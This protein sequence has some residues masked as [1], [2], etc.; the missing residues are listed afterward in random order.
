MGNVVTL[1]F[2]GD[3]TKLQQASKDSVKATDDVVDAA[4]SAGQTFQDS[5]KESA[6]F[7]DKIGKLGAGITGMGDAVDDASGALQGLADIQNANVERAAALARAQGDVE[8]AQLDGKQAARDLRQAQLDVNQ[9]QR[10]GRQA[11]IDI[12]GAQNNVNRAQFEAQQAGDALAKAIKEHGK[13]SDEAKAAAL[14]YADAQTAVKQANEDVRQAQQDAQQAVEDGKQANQDAAQAVRDSKDSQL[15]LNDAM[16]EAHPPQLQ[17]WANDLNTITPLVTGIIGLTGLATAGQYAWT[18]ATNA[19]SIG[20]KIWAAAQW[21]MNS[22]LWAS[23]ITWIVAAVVALVAVIVLIATKT[24][25]FQKLWRASWGWIKSAA[26][27]T[28]DFIKKIPGWL[29]DA[30]KGIAKVLTWP[31]RTA[32]NLIADIWNNTIGSLSWSVPGWVPVIGGNTISVPHIPK[33]HTGGVVP[34]APGSEM[35]AVLQA[36][37]TVTPA[38]GSTVIEIRSGGSQLDDLLVEILSRAVRRR[39]GNVQL[40]LG[41]R[42]A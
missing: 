29:G 27:N 21:V 12:E 32:F 15:D 4:K 2:A 40:A 24:D 23:P 28:W 38:G 10:D 3:A 7:T 19:A 30:F 20:A 34:G 33:F 39:G 13:G 16:R 36:G 9:A 22:A 37:E 25:W 18:A 5:G 41:G 26:S 42:N 17:Q 11:A 31:F 8:Q 35:L 1:E 6:S 14:D